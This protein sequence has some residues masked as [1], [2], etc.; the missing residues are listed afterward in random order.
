MV[1]IKGYSLKSVNN[2]LGHEMEPCCQGV[3]CY[4]GEEIAFISDDS[5]GGEINV[6]A[7]GKSGENAVEIA[8]QT[9]NS[10][11]DSDEYIFYYPEEFKNIKVGVSN[12]FD[13][14]ILLSTL[15]KAYDRAKKKK[16]I[17]IAYGA[18]ANVF[19]YI[20]LPIMPGCQKEKINA[21]L[22]GKGHKR[23]VYFEKDEDFNIK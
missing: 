3:L 16:A 14:L 12:L 7:M 21:Y 18:G 6:C 4:Q 17:G 1:S 5:H 8:A 2:F 13:D 15:K 23:I 11:V 20:I 19:D 22:K 9:Y 10:Y